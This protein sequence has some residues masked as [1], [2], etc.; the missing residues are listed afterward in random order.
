MDAPVNYPGEVYPLSCG[1]TVM[2]MVKH[3]PGV[4]RCK[5]GR[6]LFEPFL[7]GVLLNSPQ[8]VE[9]RTHLT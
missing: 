4:D 1:C 6:L 7:A 2:D 9:L 5:H 3:A 8:I